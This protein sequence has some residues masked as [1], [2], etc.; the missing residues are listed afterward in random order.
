METRGGPRACQQEEVEEQSVK[1]AERESQVKQNW[2]PGSHEK[3]A[4]QGGRMP[5]LANT[6]AESSTK[7]AEN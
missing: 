5:H 2:H 4:H 7:L 1:E 6:L 3:T